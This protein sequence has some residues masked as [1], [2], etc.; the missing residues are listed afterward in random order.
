MERVIK[1]AV[2]VTL[3]LITLGLLGCVALTGGAEWAIS[4]NLIWGYILLALAI[5]AVI[6]VAIVGTI[7][8]PSG[9]LKT[10]ISFVTIIVVALAAVGLAYFSGITS[11]PNS[12]GSE[13]NDFGVL[14]TAGSSLIVT[15]IAAVI[16]GL[17]ALGVWLYRAIKR[18]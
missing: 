16:A 2:L 12:D 18:W 5:L 8:H 11:I 1:I 15:Y 10:I 17:L 4:A 6:S 13:F 3:S 14:V 7:T 9:L